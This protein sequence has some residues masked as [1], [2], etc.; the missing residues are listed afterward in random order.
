MTIKEL[1]RHLQQIEKIEGDIDVSYFS[2][3]AWGD[4][5]NQS[6]SCIQISEETGYNTKVKKVILS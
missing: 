1:I 6:I 3:D 4:C 2:R 5:D